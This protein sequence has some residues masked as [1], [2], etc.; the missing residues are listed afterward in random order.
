MCFYLPF[1]SCAVSLSASGTRPFLSFIFLLFTSP[2]LYR[3]FLCISSK[4]V[5]AVPVLRV[6]VRSTSL[7]LGSGRTQS[8]QAPRYPEGSVFCASRCSENW[9][10]QPFQAPRSSGDWWYSVLSGP[11]VPWGLAGL[12]PFSPPGTLGTGVTQSFQAPRYPGD[13]RD[14]VLSAPPGTLRT[15]GTR[16]VSGPRYPWDLRESHFS[17]PS[18]LGT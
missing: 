4:V 6:P 12:S 10:T 15:G 7:T 14:S 5:T 13:W 1:L 2:I 11:R 9:G 8:F 16:V 18:T 3:F 17:P